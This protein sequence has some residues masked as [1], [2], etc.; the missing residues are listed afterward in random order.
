MEAF[1]ALWDQTRDAFAQRR[2]WRRGHDLALGTLISLGRQTVSG[3]V[4]ATGQQ[5][6]DWSA[7]YRLFAHARFDPVAL[8]AP[9][10]R[11]VQARLAPSEPLVVLM[12]DTLLRK[13]GRQIA[14]T[15]WKRDPLGPPFADNIIWAQRFLQL[16]AALPEATAD[17]VTGR[18][19]GIPI[20]M[21]H[22]PSPR[23]PSKR[24]TPEQWDQYHHARVASKIS[25]CGAEHVAALRAAMDEDGQTQRPLI[26]AAD[27]AFTNRTVLA[28]WPERTTLVGRLRK[29]AKL[30]APP[31]RTH[32]PGRGRKPQYGAALP[33]P[34]QM[35]QND[36]I[37]WQ[38]VTAF[39]AGRHFDFEVKIVGPVRWRPAGAR[40]VRMLIIRPLAYRLTQN[41]RLLYRRSVYLVAT[42]P[43]LPP[44]R[45]LQAYIWRWEIEVNFRD[46]KTLLGTGQAQVRTAAAAERVPV[47]IAAAYAYLHLALAASTTGQ[48]IDTDLPRPSWQKPKPGQRCS[49]QHA[50]QLLRA[51]LWARALGIENFSG[52]V[53]RQQAR[54]KSEQFSPDPASA[55]LYATG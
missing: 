3:M 7:F 53:H 23:K 25:R 1:D 16:S 44:A 51:L 40:N 45:I 33:T 46:Q 2:T 52:F 12:D 11:A 27:G 15:W 31:P 48:G 20:A 5:F 28:A 13:R 9:A 22:C 37:P 17:G 39:A 42:D 26:V 54:A 34:E 8:L 30:W 4:T 41:S 14:G 55:M 21:A 19:R 36:L 43:D 35:R 38:S 32:H 50:L 24:A 18:A 29:D 6:G 49:T 10:R 47:L